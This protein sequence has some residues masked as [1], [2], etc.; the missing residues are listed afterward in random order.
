MEQYSSS[1][2]TGILGC[3]TF[4]MSEEIRLYNFCNKFSCASGRVKDEIIEKVNWDSNFTFSMMRKE[5][6]TDLGAL[7]FQ[8][9]MLIYISIYLPV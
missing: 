6:S 1:S 8:V 4:V 3:T 9:I 7:S 5:F 2:S